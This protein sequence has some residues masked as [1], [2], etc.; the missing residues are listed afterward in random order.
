MGEGDPCA[1]LEAHNP[2]I[3][4]ARICQPSGFE[5]IYGVIWAVEVLRMATTDGNIF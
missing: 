5:L 1:S 4:N 3:E 2:L